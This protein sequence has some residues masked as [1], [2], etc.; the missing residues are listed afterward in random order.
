MKRL[1][2]IAAVAAAVMFGGHGRA[3]DRLIEW[4][5]YGGQQAHTKY[6][7]AA[8]ITPANVGR[9]APA[10]QWAPAEKPIEGGTRPGLFE[11]TP[12]MIDNVLY[13]STS[14]NRV[15]ALDADTGKERW[16]FDPRSAA[17]PGGAG[18]HR[19]VAYWRDG[20]DARIFLNSR[21]RLLAI[22]GYA[23]LDLRLTPQNEVVFIEANPNPILAREEDFA[24]SG[25]K[26]G[27][28]YPK[29]IDKIINLG[30]QT[31]RD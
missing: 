15:V 8:D 11:N 1:C 25:K 20:D 27:I 13:V 22:D 21:H 23:R 29:L 7:L 4:P 3:Q 10:W 18:A 16:A 24:E 14:N 5:Y 6:S 28:P 19:G 26:A 2:A 31:T 12:L 30:K 17:D 9:L